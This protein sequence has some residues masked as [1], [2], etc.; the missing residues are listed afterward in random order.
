MPAEYYCETT[1]VFSLVPDEPG[2]VG[3]RGPLVAYVETPLENTARHRIVNHWDVR[4]FHPWVEPHVL[5]PL[6]LVQ[7]DR[8]PGH[9]HDTCHRYISRH[10][11]EPDLDGNMEY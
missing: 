4:E 7:N 10:S 1:A 2:A 5:C 3:E 6:D 9:G 8:E 11:R